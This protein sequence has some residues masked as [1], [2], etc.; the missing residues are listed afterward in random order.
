MYCL[1]VKRIIAHKTLKMKDSKYMTQ[2]IHIYHTF[3]LDY[4]F[5]VLI[6]CICLQECIGSPGVGITGGIAT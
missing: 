4:Y 2:V 6:M 3:F 1:L 5:L